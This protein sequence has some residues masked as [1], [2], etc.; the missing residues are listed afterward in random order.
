MRRGDSSTS[1]TMPLSIKLAKFY[2]ATAYY[3]LELSQTKNHPN[4]DFADLCLSDEMNALLKSRMVDN[5]RLCVMAVHQDFLRFMADLE[6][7]VNGIAFDL[8][9]A[10]KDDFFSVP[11]DNSLED[12]LQSVDEAARPDSGPEQA[13]FAFICKRLRR[14]QE[15]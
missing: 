11:E 8:W 5:Y 10:H 1:V 3:L 15:S 2:G 4:A 12:F 7:Y 14:M 13:A 6:I 9:E